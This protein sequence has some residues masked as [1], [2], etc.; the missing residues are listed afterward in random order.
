MILGRASEWCADVGNSKSVTR[1]GLH[2]EGAHMAESTVLFKV[3]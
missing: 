2:S 3:L 1:V